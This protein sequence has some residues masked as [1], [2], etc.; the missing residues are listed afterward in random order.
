MG[1]LI[2]RTYARQARLQ[3]SHR[4][5]PIQL[6][7]KGAHG[8][9][10]RARDATSNRKAAMNKRQIID[11][12]RKRNTTVTVAFLNR[13]NEADLVE[14]LERLESADRKERLIAGW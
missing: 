2:I 3:G 10:G 1:D 13:F 11:Q 12:I 7:A 4:G 8:R 6:I 14:Y 5:R 9:L